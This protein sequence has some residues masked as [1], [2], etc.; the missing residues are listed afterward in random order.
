[1]VNICLWFKCQ[2]S[3][4]VRWW[5]WVIVLVL[6]IWCRT[7]RRLSYSV[8]SWRRSYGSNSSHCRSKYWLISIA[9]SWHVHRRRRHSTRKRYF[10]YRMNCR[11]ERVRRWMRIFSPKLFSTLPFK[12]NRA[13][14]TKFTF[15]SSLFSIW[16]RIFNLLIMFTKK[17]LLNSIIIRNRSTLT[18]NPIINGSTLTN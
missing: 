13:P 15:S 12:T 9:I 17:M 16:I 2:M 14:L 5:W 3:I 1:M 8:T 6:T 11:S 18:A 4:S 10:E 7:S